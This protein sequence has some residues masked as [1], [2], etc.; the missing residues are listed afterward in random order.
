M[1][2]RGSLG[3]IAQTVK[4]TAGP[5]YHREFPSHPE[6]AQLPSRSIVQVTHSAANA[7]Y[8]HWV[9]QLAD[10]WMVGGGAPGG[11]VKG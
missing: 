2:V 3:R 8:G 9:V 11:D 6:P 4:F 1:G 7:A 10:G 5:D